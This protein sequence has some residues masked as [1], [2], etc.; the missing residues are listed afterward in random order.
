MRGDVRCLDALESLFVLTI[1][2]GRLS[3]HRWAAVSLAG[4]FCGEVCPD[5][6]GFMPVAQLSADRT[7]RSAP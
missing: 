5:G 3:F 4:E 7:C 2:D 6:L 1:D